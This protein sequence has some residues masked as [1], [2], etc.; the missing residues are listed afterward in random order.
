VHIPKD[1]SG[2]TSADRAWD[3]AQGGKKSPTK[4]HDLWSRRAPFHNFCRKREWK[5]NEIQIKDLLWK[6]SGKSCVIKQIPQKLI[7]R[8]EMIENEWQGIHLLEPSCRNK[9]GHFVFYIL[10]LTPIW[11]VAGGDVSNFLRSAR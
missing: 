7:N 5:K 3:V 9:F 10:H 1:C 2:C 11:S 8:R 4:R 6:R